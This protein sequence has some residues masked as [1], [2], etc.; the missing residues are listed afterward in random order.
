MAAGR[1]P[2]PDESSHESPAGDPDLTAE[3]AAHLA[4]RAFASL[5]DDDDLL[6]RV[7]ALFR[8]CALDLEAWLVP[9][10]ESAEIL[11]VL[12]DDLEEL[13]DRAPGE[14][15]E[16]F[17]RARARGRALVARWEA[18]FAR[19]NPLPEHRIGPGSILKGK[20]LATGSA[21]GAPCILPSAQSA[22]GPPPGAVLVVPLV[23]PADA[24]VFSRCAALICE[25]GAVLGHA[26]V[27]AREKKIPAL[28]LPRACSSLAHAARVRVDGSRGEVE[29][30]SMR[31]EGTSR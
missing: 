28:V 23:L 12:P 15:R 25:S 1:R 29:I 5:E 10:A 6:G 19:E 8:G 4:V 27:L 9:E 2:L 17:A 24:I 18:E 26:A 22:G 14:R 16:R 13:L 11:E 21:S 3:S 30:L 7:Y 20:A 31:E